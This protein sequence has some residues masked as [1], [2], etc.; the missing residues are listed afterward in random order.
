MLNPKELSEMWQW[1]V[2]TQAYRLV[3]GF[4][5]SLLPRLPD[6]VTAGKGQ[7]GD[8]CALQAGRGGEGQGQREASS[9]KG[10]KAGQQWLA[11][12]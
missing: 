5:W 6:K 8:A 10:I 11:E 12:N 3:P 1:W 9:H 2:G 7:A 4:T